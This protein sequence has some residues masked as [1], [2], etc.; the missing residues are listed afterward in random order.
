MEGETL[1]GIL[2]KGR[3]ERERALDIGEA[4]C[5]AI[6]YAHENGIIHR[7]LKPGN[8]LI[9]K[10][11]GRVVV[12]DFGLA[13]DASAVE[14]T[15]TGAIVGTFEKLQMSVES[16]VDYLAQA[17]TFRVRRNFFEKCAADL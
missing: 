7:D 17:D 10:G 9:E 15:Q 6:G 13:K 4:L 3:M 12:V 5:K 1:M 14:L 11:S 2:K 16:M 8:V